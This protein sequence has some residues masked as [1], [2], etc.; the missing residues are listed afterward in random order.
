M[1]DFV[2]D[3]SALVKRHVIEPGSTWVKSLVGATPWSQ[4]MR[5]EVSVGQIT[6]G[7]QD[8]SNAISL[9]SPPDDVPALSRLAREEA[10]TWRHAQYETPLA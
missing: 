10:A 4:W 3:A 8:G 9:A 2:L 5:S 7:C 1:A 6:R